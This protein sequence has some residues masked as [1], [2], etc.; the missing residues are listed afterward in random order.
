MKAAPEPPAPRQ[1]TSDETIL[2]VKG[3]TCASCV[4]RVERALAKAP[5]VE[6][7]SVN[8]AT[9][10]ATVRHTADVDPGALITAVDRAGYEAVPR[11]IHDLHT[12]S[13]HAEHLRQESEDEFRSMGRNLA[14]AAVLTVPVFAISMFYHPRPESWN[15]LLFLLTTPVIF[16]CGRSFFIIA[17]RAGRHG[18]TTMDTLVAIGSGAAWAYSVYGLFAFRGNAHHQSEAIYFETGAVIVTLI[19]L[20]RFLEAKAK[21]RMSDS[22]RKLMDLTPKEATVVSDDGSERPISASAL[23]PGHVVRVRPGERMPADGEVVSGDSYVDESMLTGEPVPVPK[24]V[25]DRVTGGTVNGQ[26]VLVFRVDRT[27]KDTILA[28]IARL[29]EHAQGSKAPL[30]S[31][32]DKVSSIFVPVVILVALLTVAAYGLFG[33]GWTDGLLRSVAVLVIACPCALG[34]ATP[35]ALMVGTG[36]GAELGI[37]IR[38]GNA[39]ERAASIST[40]LLDKTG[41]LTAGQPTLTDLVTV[42]DWTDYDALTVAA[43]LESYSEHPIARAVVEAGAK[44]SA[45]SVTVDEFLA[46]SGQGVAGK[47]DDL[48]ARIGKVAWVAGGDPIPVAVSQNV[49]Q[50][51]DEGKTTIVLRRGPNWAILAVTDPIHPHSREAVSAL[52]DLGIEPVMVTGDQPTAAQRV[53]E[54]VGILRVKAQVLPAEK[55]KIA[56]EFQSVSPTAM[57]GDGINDAP[58]LAQADLGI[59]M[60]SGTDIAMET[61][62]M[63]LL[64]A[65]LRGVPTA[66]RLARATLSTIKG[67]LFWAFAYNVV[68]IPLAVVGLM[69]PMLA[70]AAM[71]FS[72]ISVILNSLRLRRFG[73]SG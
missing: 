13:E 47:V 55:A 17:A 25:G 5:G 51:E 20:G 18:T 9:H 10:Q 36:R 56:Q 57:V 71:A 12:S 35:T 26:G 67:N 60:A 59:A 15:W 58:A 72:S 50:F 46:E 54:A 43:S 70:A 37:L 21:G 65:D 31:L 53:A 29:V 1:P 62:G 16:W 39:L 3:M 8:F 19:L 23:V 2:D 24:K 61:A 64:R 40:V 48:P 44:S 14:F 66:I 49:A 73:R 22:I 34:L 6:S 69:S 11:S 28:Q 45:A 42:G 4:A 68:M 7:A 27:G 33:S 63:T 41:T 52:V 30:Q 32:A 38:D